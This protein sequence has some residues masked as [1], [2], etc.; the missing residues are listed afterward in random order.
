M[1]ATVFLLFLVGGLFVASYF[2]KRRFG[3]LG[4]GLAA[5][6]LL[7]SYWVDSLTPFIVGQGFDV[8]QSQVDI[9]VTLLPAM[10]LLFGGPTYSKTHMRVIGSALF[11]LLALALVLR[12]LGSLIQFDEAGMSIYSLVD[13]YQGMIIVIGLL[14]AIADVFVSRPS[15]GLR[16]R[17]ADH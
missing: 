12:P 13:N 14:L 17:K 4:L 10:A 8:T 11:S 6:A 2:M 15:K 3:I 9:V 16:P 7:S 5:G 1:N